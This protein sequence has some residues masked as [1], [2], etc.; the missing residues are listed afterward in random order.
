MSL[1]E[2]FTRNYPG[3]SPESPSRFYWVDDFEV[4]EASVLEV[5][6]I[7][8]GI[9]IPAPVD[10]KEL[11]LESAKLPISGRLQITF[12]RFLHNLRSTDFRHLKT[13]STVD[14]NE[15]VLHE[16]VK[17]LSR[18]SSLPPDEMLDL[19]RQVLSLGNRNAH[20][21]SAAII[22]ESFEGY[23][24]QVDGDTAYVTLESREF[25]DVLH[26]EYSAALLLQKGIEEQTRFLCKTIKLGETTRIEFEALPDVEVTNEEVRAIA[27]R[28]DRAF[29]R[30]DSGIEY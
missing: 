13:V 7:E 28:I 8:D 4:E 30:D 25:G 3:H 17:L 20:V 21:P 11:F 6:D 23:V 24:D 18:I 15:Q 26:G 1:A 27:D 29:P 5:E 10:S 9:T 16:S 12:G 19:L 2:A 22:G 14:T